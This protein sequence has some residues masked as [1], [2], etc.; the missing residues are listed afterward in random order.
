MQQPLIIQGGMGVAISDWKL[1][2]TV[3]QLGQMGVVSGT[4][5]SRVMT[6]RLMDGDPDGHVRRALAHFPYPNLADQILGKYFIQGGKAPDEPYKNLPAY[7]LTPPQALDQLTVIANFVEVWL[8][9][10][11]HDGL[12]GIN[13]LEKVQMPNMAS[14]YGAMLAG[15][16]YVL[17]GAGIPTQIPGILECLAG[18]HA[19]SYR[20]DVAGATQDDDYRLPF[21]PQ[22]IFPELAEQVGPLR[23][24]SFLPIISS[25]VLAKALLKRSEGAVDG[26]IIEG[27]LAGGHNAP[28]RAGQLDA[29]GEPLYTDKD[30]VDLGK[31]RELGLPFWLAGN[32]GSAEGL[33][34]ALEAG[35]A[36]IQVGT[37]FAFC[38]DSGMEPGYRAAAVQQALAGT[39]QVFTNPLASPTGFPFKTV[40]LDGTMTDPTVYQ[41]RERLCDM[42]FLRQVYKREDETLGYRCPSEPVEDYLKKGGTLE[43]TFGRTC[44]CNNLGAAAGF[45]QV[46]RDGY[47]EKPLIT[48]GN[49]LM[50]I[51]RFIPAG[52]SHYSAAD[53]VRALLRAVQRQP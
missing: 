51:G 53:V 48:A 3:A 7:T 14:L 27:P 38:D 6:A 10:E 47:V 16:D 33:Q 24:P 37:A 50:N 4:G 21:D 49:D 31:I 52:Q 36:G 44:L 9:K 28:P 19:V 32:Y 12:I 18:H 26:F 22:A 17:M 5:L 41:A 11:G 35:A 43:E 42:R 2:R 45:A 34:A 1:A 20:V 30:D 13:L 29:A 39:V 15:V 23:R 40:L 46:R 8:A 25:V